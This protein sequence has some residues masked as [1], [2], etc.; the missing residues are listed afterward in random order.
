MLPDAVS[1]SCRKRNEYE[2]RTLIFLLLPKPSLVIEYF[3]V[4]EVLLVLECPHPA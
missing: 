3:R 4:F 2:I 1:S